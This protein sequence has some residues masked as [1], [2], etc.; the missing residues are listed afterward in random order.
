MDRFCS[1]C[2][3]V[4]VGRIDKKFCTDQCRTSYNNKPENRSNDTIRNINRVLVNNRR[5]LESIVGNKSEVRT[6]RVMLISR[7][8]EPEFCT[9]QLLKEDGTAKTGCYDFVLENE[10]EN[11]LKIYRMLD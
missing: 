11:K 9:H 8:Y 1:E 7:G 3:K 10:S 6:S 4:L 5:I 2:N